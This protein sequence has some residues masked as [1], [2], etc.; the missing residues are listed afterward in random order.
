MNIQEIHSLVAECR[1][2]GMTAKAWCEAKGNNGMPLYRQEKDWAN[3][4]V[5]LSRATLASFP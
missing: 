5:V 1:A 4:G 3:Q 2:S